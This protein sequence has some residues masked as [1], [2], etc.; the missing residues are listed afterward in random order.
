MI[1]FCYS[2]EN[3]VSP[4]RLSVL[5]AQCNQYWGGNKAT[6]PGTQCAHSSS[7]E[8]HAFLPGWACRETICRAFYVPEGP[9]FPVGLALLQMDIRTTS[10]GA[11]PLWCW[12]NA[13]DFS[14][15]ATGVGERLAGLLKLGSRGRCFLPCWASVS[16][17]A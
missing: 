10:D 15:S 16:S 4:S 1:K 9:S 13:C 17:S 8:S 5:R 2:R 3:K 12:L 11:G 14:Q 7:L 6:D